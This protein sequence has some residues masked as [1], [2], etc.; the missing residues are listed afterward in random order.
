VYS[1]R[2]VVEFT[3]KLYNLLAADQPE[4]SCAHESLVGQNTMILSTNGGIVLAK[5]YESFCAGKL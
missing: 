2:D 5:S 1:L 3:A 4:E